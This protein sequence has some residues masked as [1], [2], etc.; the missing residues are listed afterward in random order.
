MAV[1]T[2]PGLHLLSLGGVRVICWEHLLHYRRQYV[3]CLARLANLAIAVADDLVDVHH[4]IVQT[5]VLGLHSSHVVLVMLHAIFK[6]LQS[7]SL[8]E[9]L[10]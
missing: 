10:S 8:S 7:S 1:F 9:W 5:L 4:G 3:C 6:S 2:L